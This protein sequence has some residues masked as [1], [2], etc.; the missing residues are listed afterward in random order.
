MDRM[1][2]ST[3][4]ISMTRLLFRLIPF[5][6]RHESALCLRER[7]RAIIRTGLNFFTLLYQVA[8]INEQI[9]FRI[10][11]QVRMIPALSAIECDAWIIIV[12]IQ[13]PVPFRI[14][15]LSVCKCARAVCASANLS[16]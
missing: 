6:F 9:S 7:S 3:E 5:P 2:I 13:W 10:G 4:E 11:D 12:M 1:L 15:H 16:W 8:S 14:I